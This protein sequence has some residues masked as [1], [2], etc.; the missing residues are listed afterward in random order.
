MGVSQIRCKITTHGM[1]QEVRFSKKMQKNAFFSSFLYFFRGTNLFSFLGANLFSFL[2]TNSLNHTFTQKCIFLSRSA[3]T[4][5]QKCMFIDDFCKF[6]CTCQKKAVPLHAESCKKGLHANDY[7]LL[8]IY[9]YEMSTMRGGNP[10]RQYVLLKMR[11][12]S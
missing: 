11:K 3:R 6:I 1:S 10:R 7:K 5:I 4:I 8:N 12:R 2:G 9:S